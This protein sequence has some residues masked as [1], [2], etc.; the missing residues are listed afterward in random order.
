MKRLI[1]IRHGQSE[2]NVNY[3]ILK[4]IHEEDIRLTE[5]GYADATQAGVEL[6]DM[7][8]RFKNEEGSD[9]PLFVVSPWDRAFQ[10]YRFVAA[11]LN[12]DDSTTIIDEEVVEHHMNLQG[13]DA[14]WEKFLKYKNSEWNTEQ[15]MHETWEGGE[16][17]ANVRQRAKN[18]L[19]FATELA[20][21]LGHNNIVLV[22]HGQFIKMVLCELDGTDPK[23]V[24]H[25]KN[26]EV[27]VRE[28]K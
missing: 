14:N 16:T 10:T 27:N 1:L 25:P 26:G 20:H 18:F 23:D 22:S 19:G 13:S 11:V 3:D 7:L 17:L 15:F 6:K 9:Q 5:K 28:I 12:H 8:S 4:N 21:A 24:W 2:A